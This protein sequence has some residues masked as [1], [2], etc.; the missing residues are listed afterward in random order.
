MSALRGQATT[1]DSGSAEAI[2]L[3]LLSE[4]LDLL[5][6]LGEQLGEAVLEG[7]HG[8]RLSA[9]IQ[10]ISLLFF[11]PIPSS[12]GI[13]TPGASRDQSKAAMLLT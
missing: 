11:F 6:L 8:A 7:L 12:L 13:L 4:S 10:P 9:S 1:G 5:N 3:D 2:G